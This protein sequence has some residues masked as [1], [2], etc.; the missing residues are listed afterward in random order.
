[1]GP[2]RGSLDP[3]CYGNRVDWSSCYFWVFKP[4]H[5][6]RSRLKRDQTCWH[7][8]RWCH[9]HRVN[10]ITT[11]GASNGRPCE[12]SDSLRSLRVCNDVSFVAFRWSRQTQSFVGHRAVR[13]GHAQFKSSGFSNS[14]R[15][16]GDGSCNFYCESRCCTNFIEVPTYSAWTECNEIRILRSTSVCNWSHGVH[17]VTRSACIVIARVYCE[18]CKNIWI[19]SVKP[20]VCLVLK[21]RRCNYDCFWAIYTSW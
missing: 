11:E 21:S 2:R 4:G 19:C 17:N 16:G 15:G 12:F 20:C 6:S 8:V 10:G 3:T 1:M 7:A 18:L 13:D 14:P 5:H 9:P